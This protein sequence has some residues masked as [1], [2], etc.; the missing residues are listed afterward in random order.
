MVKPDKANV[1]MTDVSLATLTAR[2]HRDILATGSTLYRPRG[3]GVGADRILLCGG[4]TKSRSCFKVELDA[5]DARW[6]EAEFQTTTEIALGH[7]AAH[8]PGTDAIWIAGGRNASSSSN[9]NLAKS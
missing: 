1:R 4:E 3:A 7:L 5:H 9:R 8:I 6:E 2:E